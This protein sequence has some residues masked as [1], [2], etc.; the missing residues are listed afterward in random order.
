MGSAVATF[1]TFEA[2]NKLSELLERAEGGEEI[3]ITRRGR[4]IAKIVSMSA[5]TNRDRARAAAARI[6]QRASQ[7]GGRFDWAEWKQHRDEGRP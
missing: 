3:I 7:L 4:A 2:K 1:G 6:R 5:E